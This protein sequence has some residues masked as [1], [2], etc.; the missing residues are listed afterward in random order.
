MPA[1]FRLASLTMKSW[2]ESHPLSIPE[3]HADSAITA[4]PDLSPD[5]WKGKVD[6]ARNI[7]P[8]NLKLE[9]DAAGGLGRHL[10]LFSTTLL[11]LVPLAS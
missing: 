1:S 4:G 8:G 3:K 6:E 5:G 9:E 7:Q 11:M 10:G 2:Q